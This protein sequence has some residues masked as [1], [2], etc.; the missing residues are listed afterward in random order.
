MK[1]GFQEVHEGEN[2]ACSRL[3]PNDFLHRCPD[4]QIRGCWLCGDNRGDE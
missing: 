3:D 2:W 4:D 1:V